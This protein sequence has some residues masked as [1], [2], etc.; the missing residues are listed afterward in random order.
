MARRIGKFAAVLSVGGMNAACAAGLRPVRRQ[1]RKRNWG[2]TDRTGK[3][4]GAIGKVR[5]YK[6]RT[7]R[8]KGPGAYIRGGSLVGALLE[9]RYGGR[10]SWIGPALGLTR[11][12]SLAA[13]T[14]RARRELTK[15]ATRARSR[16]R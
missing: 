12:A 3:T 7:I 11:S 2:F 9:Y 1:M 13:F 5:R 16:G 15:A 8:R 10:F 14:A 6:R 4:R